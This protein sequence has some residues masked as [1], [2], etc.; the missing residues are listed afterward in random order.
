MLCKPQFRRRDGRSM[1]ARLARRTAPQQYTPLQVAKIYGLPIPSNGGTLDGSGQT[2]GIVEL[3]G[4]FSQSDLSAYLQQ[5]G[6]PDV[7]V[8]CINVAGGSQQSDPGGADVE[9]MLDVCIIA[10]LAPK[11]AI[12]IYFGP[13]SDTG[14]PSCINQAAADGCDAISISWGSPE[15]Q[16]P[17]SYRAAVDAA[18]QAAIHAGVTVWAAAGDNGSSDGTGGTVADFPASSP[19][20]AGCG[21]TNLQPNGS[22]TVW[23]D[24]SQGGATG[25]GFSQFYPRPAY[26][27][28]A[29]SQAG[30]GVPDVCGNADPETGWLIMANGA[31]QSVGGTSAVAPMWAAINALKNQQMDQRIGFA[32]VLF[33]ANAG[34]FNDTI[35][36]NNGAYQAG[37]GWDA[38]TGLGS[39]KGAALFAASAAPPG[40]PAPLP[41]SPPAPLPP[42]PPSPLP[43]PVPAPTGFP[44]QQIIGVVDSVF[45]AVEGQVP[46]LPF[47]QQHPFLGKLLV[48]ALQAINKI[49][50]QDLLQMVSGQARSS[51]DPT[52]VRKEL[53]VAYDHLTITEKA[54]MTEHIFGLPPGTLIGIGVKLLPVLLQLLGSLQQKPSVASHA[55]A[56]S[57]LTPGQIKQIFDGLIAFAETM[58]AGNATALQIL[59]FLQTAID[60]ILSQQGS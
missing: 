46:Q 3:G 40:P 12:R 14:M 54:T 24:G 51:L 45:A 34:W 8:Q 50:D 18:C 58:F 5:L 2:I 55:A 30:R 20:V 49:I 13:N 57:A 19:Y 25:G 27:S 60:A 32:N 59:G 7:Q 1:A 6:L 28:A 17:A 56:P 23:N 48:Y 16:S 9:V 38:C 39:P 4:A 26:Q 10:A 31:L 21:G 22:E 37:P 41:P 43:P 35:T 47:I 44:I 33:Y 52:S 36:G 11:A 42:S 53:A 29:N 15:T